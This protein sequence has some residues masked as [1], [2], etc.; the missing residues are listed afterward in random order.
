[1]M[2]ARLVAP[3]IMI[4]LLAGGCAKDAENPRDVPLV[5]EPI[6]AVDRDDR[7][8]AATAE[9][10]EHDAG[11]GGPVVDAPPR[12]PATAGARWGSYGKNLIGQT[13]MGPFQPP[14]Q[15]V[16]AAANAEDKELLQADKTFRAEARRAYLLGVLDGA[17]C[18]NDAPVQMSSE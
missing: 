14:I 6:A 11:L 9:L 5:Y 12:K 15:T 7:C 3:I 1:M 4:S 10:A 8:V 2:P 16:R 18:R 13:L 17:D